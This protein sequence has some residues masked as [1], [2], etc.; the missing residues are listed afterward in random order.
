VETQFH[1]IAE[2]HPTVSPQQL[3]SSENMT[4]RLFTMGRVRRMLQQRQIVDLKTKAL[5]YDALDYLER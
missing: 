1:F 2:C 4:R 3:D 5:L